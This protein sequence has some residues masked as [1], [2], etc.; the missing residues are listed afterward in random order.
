MERHDIMI[1]LF[2]LRS[3]VW[4]CAYTY[5]SAYITSIRRGVKSIDRSI[6]SFSLSYNYYII[7]YKAFTL[8]Y[9]ARGWKYCWVII[10]CLILTKARRRTRQTHH[11][12]TV[13]TFLGYRCKDYINL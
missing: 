12:Y 9:L 10:F 2:A 6:S 8:K 1:L 5:D 3:Y 11:Q 7:T 4:L 13:H